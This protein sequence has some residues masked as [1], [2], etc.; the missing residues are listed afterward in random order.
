MGNILMIIGNLDMTCFGRG[1]GEVGG[2]VFKMAAGN[3]VCHD[4]RDQLTWLDTMP[5][6]H[7]LD[8]NLLNMASKYPFAFC[9][10]SLY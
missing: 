7:F 9:V 10:G 4:N 2:S 5:N 6:L 1:G 8:L 3:V